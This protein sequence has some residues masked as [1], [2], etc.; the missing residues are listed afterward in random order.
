MREKEDSIV[1][2]LANKL[3]PIDL[4]NENAATALFPEYNFNKPYGV[5]TGGIPLYAVL[6]FYKSLIVHLD[7]ILSPEKFKTTYG[8]TVDEMTEL[9]EK[10]RLII[11][12]RAQYD[13]FPKFYRPLLNDHVPLNNRFEKIYLSGLNDNISRYRDLLE[14]RYPFSEHNFISELHKNFRGKIDKASI[15][16]YALSLMAQR[17][18][19]LKIIGLEET[20]KLTLSNRKLSTAYNKLHKLNRALAVPT[21]DTLGGWDNLDEK[22][23]NL[24]TQGSIE[25][26]NQIVF[27]K[28]ILFWFNKQ[29]NYSY[30]S[31]LE[32]GGAYLK[33]IEEID[34][35]PE[36]HK[37]LLALQQ[38]FLDSNYDNSVN[39]MESSDSLLSGIKKRLTE[40]EKTQTNFRKWISTPIRYASLPISAVSFSIAASLFLS[41]ATPAAIGWGILGAGSEI[42][43][44]HTDKIE[45]FLTR[46]IHGRKA[47]P[48]I[49]WDRMSKKK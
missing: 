9:R 41:S 28:E 37:L 20:V 18:A 43:R 45:S 13:F 29:M 47:V 48:V 21:I 38:S 19:K 15:K 36:N 34:E 31:S 4:Y 11:L 3:E 46:L 22:H 44:H 39:I 49:M 25:N 17:M 12:L 35:V 10:G 26:N 23:L 32:S 8:F 6:P 40:I 7:P 30:P 5:W 1:Q 24:I 33:S 42:V 2:A 14:K 27:P 16:E